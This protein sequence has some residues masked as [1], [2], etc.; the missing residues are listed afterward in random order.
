MELFHTCSTTYW[1]ISFAWKSNILFF[2][3]NWTNLFGYIFIEL[4]IFTQLIHLSSADK[5]FQQ[6]QPHVLLKLK[7]ISLSTKRFYYTRSI[8]HTKFI[9][10]GQTTTLKVLTAFL[11]QKYLPIFM[12]WLILSLLILKKIFH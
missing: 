9:N 7:H 11:K 10:S 1:F 12:L 3:E 6:Q 8:T 2:G 4:K 5:I